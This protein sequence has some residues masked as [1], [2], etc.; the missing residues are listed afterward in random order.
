MKMAA[1]VLSDDDPWR[2]GF[3][4][5]KYFSRIL[6]KSAVLGNYEVLRST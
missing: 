5:P 2:C 4:S 3:S 1:I 6:T